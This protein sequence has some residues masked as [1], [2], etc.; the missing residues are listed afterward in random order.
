MNQT[1][2]T[3]DR[4]RPPDATHGGRRRWW[5]WLVVAVAVLV[6]GVVLLLAIL[7]TIASSRMGRGMIEAAVNDSIE[8]R[9]TL[10]ELSIGWTRGP[11]VGDVT[12]YDPQGRVVLALKEAQA[13]K[14]SLLALAGGRRSPG[15]V[16]V[17][18]LTADVVED[19]QGVTN[20][21][22]ALALRPG[23]KV[24][25]PGPAAAP[26]AAP[27]LRIEDLS[28]QIEEVN[29]SYQGPAFEPVSVRMPRLT[30]EGRADGLLKAVWNAT[31]RQGDEEGVLRGDVQVTG[32]VDASGLL[33]P[34]EAQVAAQ[35]TVESLP[36]AAVDRLLRQG[37]ALVALLGPTLEASVTAQGST[38]NLAADVDVHSRHLV[39]RGVVRVNEAGL[40]VQPG[41][42]AQLTLTPEAWTKLLAGGREDYPR[43]VEAAVLDL[44]VDRLELPRRQ[45]AG[46]MREAGAAAMARLA[47]GDLLL[48]SGETRLGRLA[49]R[50]LGVQAA[51]DGSTRAMA[52]ALRGAAEQGDLAGKLHLDSTITFAAD[53]RG[54]IDWRRG[55]AVTAA[56]IDGLP[57]GLVDELAGTAGLLQEAIGRRLDVNATSRLAFTGDGGAPTGDFDVSVQ[58]DRLRDV[59]LAGRV[60]ADA[61]EL[62]PG[63][64]GV[65][66]LRPQLLAALRRGGDDGQGVARWLDVRQPTSLSLDVEAWR[67]PLTREA[68]D[69]RVGLSARIEAL[70][71]GPDSA[72]GRATLGPVTASLPAGPLSEGVALTVEA[73]LRLGE[74]AGHV[75]LHV[76]DP[77]PLRAARVLAIDGDATVVLT[78]GVFESLKRSGLV[79]LPAGGEGLTLARAA[80]I[81][82]TL[83]KITLPIGQPQVA[84]GA[85]A[86]LRVDALALAGDA[87]FAD[88]TLS[89]IE[90]AIQSPSVGR[91]MSATVDAQL[92]V[93][94]RSGKLA[95]RASGSDLD[96]GEPTLEA[97][98]TAEQ[99]PTALLA[100]AGSAADRWSV[101]LG[102]TLDSVQLT[103]RP[104]GASGES[105]RLQVE[106]AST[107]LQAQISGR[108]A[109]GQ[110]A[111][112]QQGST[113]RLT[114]RPQTFAA[115]QQAGAGKTAF[116]L[117]EPADVQVVVER[118]NAALP[119]P[120]EVLNL[121]GL[122]MAVDLNA[123]RLDLRRAADSQ[124]I[125]IDTL[126]ARV[127]TE[128]MHR[129]LSIDA[130]ASV[131]AADAAGATR[132]WPLRSTT[133]LTGLVDESGQLSANQAVVETDTQ[134]EQLPAS[135][136][137]ALAGLDARYV[138][139]IGQTLSLTA[140]GRV[141]GALDL[142][143]LSPNINA[144]M[145][146]SVSEQR[147]L[148][149]REDAVLTMKLTPQ[150]ADA[151][152][153]FGSPVLVDAQAANQPI[154]L[155][156]KADGFAVPVVGF[157][158]AKTALDAR[159]ELGELTMRRGWA[160]G[161]W[162]VILRAIATAV[163][164]RSRLSLLNPQQDRSMTVIF[165][166]LD[167]HARNGKVT[168]NDLWMYN[169]TTAM[170][171]K[172]D[173]DL[174]SRRI[175]STMGLYGE[176]ILRAIPALR[177]EGIITAQTIYEL[178]VRGTLDEPKVESDALIGAIAQS[179]GARQLG[180][181]AGPE[182]EAAVGILGAILEGGG[183]A[184]AGA[185]TGG[186][187]AGWPNLP[188][189]PPLDAASQ[190][191]TPR[192]DA[193][194]G[195][196]APEP[197][198]REARPEDVGLRILGGLLQRAGEGKEKEKD[199]PRP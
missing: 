176:A 158:P 181:L 69:A 139:V 133:R 46:T 96:T 145:K 91:V 168:T 142:A 140:R 86:S 26:A 58:A 144:P 190:T 118:L 186:S 31:I 1:Q 71:L 127:A 32:L 37:G 30:V 76:K 115:W 73:P 18:G 99:F 107:N 173:V 102:P 180:R 53:E 5:K 147:I 188:Q 70:E 65:I 116:V 111:S 165:T 119:G 87:R 198:K 161:E 134:A 151:L 169:A 29:L 50:G 112:L 3:S 104:E 128:D 55:E 25:E 33:A 21:E 182:A 16:T 90:A 4:S 92:Q 195:A 89:S 135:L 199:A 100:L 77:A 101:L 75:T 22:Q 20:L 44:S 160:A 13:P 141:P 62:R 40:V 132:V 27:S 56:G 45:G 109:A 57:L 7:P 43:L 136:V 121:R 143:L 60:T 79:K 9:L 61:V 166:P 152:L 97:S 47:L 159:L 197:P 129:Q 105:V 59:R 19:A 66:E 170:G 156:V 88:V 54:G 67:W 68:S 155:T 157:E 82:L 124:P 15:T 183:K 84:P 148:G 189:L 194:A 106:V 36:V 164:P 184:K 178:P 172:G 117:A 108:Y 93:A 187:A 150:L 110:S 2:I 80:R 10:G 154:R 6:V 113:V 49:V 130:R 131:A 38:L 122:T 34:R 83:G 8:G 95:L 41:A 137:V 72:V 14:L 24:V 64:V 138:G 11:R 120:G 163:D 52:L 126:A 185:V 171:F 125:V 51:F 81:D 63:R 28:L 23:A 114:L 74:D 35:A 174:V 196:N 85:E 103:L 153:K 94:E 17:R 98:V 162:E 78:P 167:V 146:L 39:A 42:G 123:T 12:V 179:A 175:N 192:E 191:P 48:D 177:G 193:A 149:L